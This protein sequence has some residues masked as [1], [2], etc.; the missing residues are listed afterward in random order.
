[1]THPLRTALVVG[2]AWAMV[3]TSTVLV[4]ANVAAVSPA[5]PTQQLSHRFSGGDRFWT[6]DDTRYFS[7]WFDGRHRIMIPYGCTRAPYYA[8]DPRCVRQRGFHHGIDIAMK[9]GTKLF[10]IVR[11]RIAPRWGAGSLGA[12]YGSKAFRLRSK[13]RDYVFGHVRRSYFNPGQRIRRGELIARAGKR[14]APDGCH[15]H[16]EVRPQGASYTQAVEPRERLKLSRR[17]Q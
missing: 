10:S 6:K 16:F 5:S 12:A 8:P 11:G 1:M 9:C 4:G 14:G 2:L 15:L 13:G 3:V 17:S 7:P